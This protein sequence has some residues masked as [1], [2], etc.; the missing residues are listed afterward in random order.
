MY[1]AMLIGAY[2]AGSLVCSAILIAIVVA[3]GRVSRST[4]S[5]LS[6]PQSDL[7]L[8]WDSLRQQVLDD[9]EPTIPDRGV[10]ADMF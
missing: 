1:L 10:V 3:N 9:S 8:Q 7:D 5:P 4:P 6:N 2:V